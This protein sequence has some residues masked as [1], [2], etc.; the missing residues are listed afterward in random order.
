M[1]KGIKGAFRMNTEYCRALLNHS[2][3]HLKL[4]EY[5]MLTILKLKFK[6]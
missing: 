5:W 4:I 6:T 2:I 3:V 1:V